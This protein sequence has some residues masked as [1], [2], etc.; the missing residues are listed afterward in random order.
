MLDTQE[1]TLEEQADSILRD[2]A[3]SQGKSLRKGGI[4]D[5]RRART[6]RE[7]EVSFATFFARR[8]IARGR[9]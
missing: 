4:I 8:G 7:R 1:P 5:E 2:W 9:A 6:V 3:K